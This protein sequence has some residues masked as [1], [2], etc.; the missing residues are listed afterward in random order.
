MRR[1]SLALGVFLCLSAPATAQQV[2]PIV[3]ELDNGMKFLLIPR[4]GDPNISAGW[5]TKVGSV[6]ESAGTTG[7][8][9][10]FEHMM[11]KG[12]DTIGTTDAEADR[13]VIEHL[14]GL[15]AQI[16]EHEQ[17]L[18]RQERLG[19]ID[20]WKNPEHRTPAHQELMDDFQTALDE[21]KGLIIKDD[22]DRIYTGQGASG[23]NA[24]TGNDFTVYFIN[25]PAN[26][27]ELWFWMESDRLQNPVFREFY[28]ERDVVHEERRL[29]VDSTPTG[30]LTEQFNAMF[31]ESS[32]YGWPI[33]G[34]PSD[35]YGMTREEA[36]AFFDVYYA[37]N[38]LAA[39]LVGDFDPD[40]AIA[41]AEQYFG[42]IPRGP[43]EPEPVRTWEMEQQGEKRMYGTADTT[44][45]VQIRYHTVADG[46]VDEPAL[47]V[48]GQ[49]LSGRTG[50]LFKSIVEEQELATQASGGQNGFKYDGYFQL[51][52]LAKDGVTPEQ[53]EEAIYSEIEKLKSEVV[54]ERELQK[55]KNQN[56][57]AEFRRLQGSFGLMVQLLLNE[58]GRGWDVINTVGPKLQAVTVE[59]IQ[60]VANEY[61][62]DD[63]RAVA[64]Y[65]RDEN[66]APVDPR[67]AGLDDAE[68]QQIGMVQQQLAGAT[69]EL[70]PQLQQQLV[71]MEAQAS[72]VPEENQDMFQLILELVR[73][74]IAELEEEGQ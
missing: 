20:D 65:T 74:R 29:R 51:T 8:A 60:R 53:V 28:S 15:H 49:V 63:K 4:P 33:G 22:F 39:A 17:E 44:P 73:E 2:T 45:Q 14:D 19:L 5:V 9:H 68:R 59:D 3:H 12:T 70:L 52:G 64:I 16:R 47:V 43:R 48:M 66:A 37:P 50:R 71:G 35:L 24:G 1:I 30:L 23:M 13:R 56:A 38:N 67:L 18:I 46:H 26:K 42:G 62:D 69:A 21:Q 72:Q 6:N 36:L 61:F 58:A 55:V 25:V 54:G 10:L 40:E 34:W 41:W 27:L 32:P 57:A 31:W 7:V 11:F